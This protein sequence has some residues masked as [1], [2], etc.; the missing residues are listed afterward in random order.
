MES[1]AFAHHQLTISRSDRSSANQFA[2]NLT[3]PLSTRP[4]V[5]QMDVNWY[6]LVQRAWLAKATATKNETEF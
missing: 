1:S 3:K 4:H 6:V 5:Q 2:D